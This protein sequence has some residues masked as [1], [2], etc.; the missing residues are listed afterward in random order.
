MDCRIGDC[1]IVHREGIIVSVP[2][3]FF[4]AAI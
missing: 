3:D 4:D 2:P 1:R